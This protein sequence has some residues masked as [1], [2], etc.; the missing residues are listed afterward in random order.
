MHLCR[1][2]SGRTRRVLVMAVL[3][4]FVGAAVPCVYA[5]PV[6]RH[7]ES[8]RSESHE[9][10]ALEEQWR[11]ALLKNDASAID[12]MTTEDFLSITSNGTLSDKPEYLHRISTHVNEFSTFDLKVL[13][14]RVQPG[15][16]IATSETHVI[17]TLDGRPVDG[18]F[19]YTK[20]YTR[21]AGGAWRVANFEVTRVSRGAAGE[22][23][24]E[25]GTPLNAAPATSQVAPH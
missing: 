13:K 20:V 15:S 25:R 21:S 12:K 24:M 8:R 10:E 6:K 9:I 19:R 23:G 22:P 17:G 4:A 16:A 18:V 2:A 1:L 11:D 3:C 7:K 14:V 5:G